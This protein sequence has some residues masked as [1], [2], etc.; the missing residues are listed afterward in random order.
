MPA[1]RR[2]RG[3]DPE[4]AQKAPAA[5]KSRVANGDVP[6]PAPRGRGRPR[7]A[8]DAARTSA[9]PPVLNTRPSQKL[10]IYVFGAGEFGELGLGSKKHEDKRPTNVKQP[11]LNHLLS[12][13]KVGVVQ[14]ACGGMHNIALTHDNRVLTWGVNDDKALGRETNWEGDDDDD[15]DDDAGLD[16][17]E[18]TPAE[19][20]F[21][22]LDKKPNF[23]Q[24]AATNSASFALTD[25]GY[26]YGWGTFRGSDGIF[27]FS[28][29]VEVQARPVKVAGLENITTLAAGSDHMLA[30]DRDGR[31]LTWGSGG[32]YQL[33]RK[34]VS[35]HGGPKATLQPMVCGRFT[36][37][38]HAVKI[39]AGA[40]TGFYIDNRSNVWSW[41]L[42]NYSQT[43]HSDQAGKS[44]AVVPAPTVVRAFQ[45]KGIIHIDGGAHHSLACSSEGELFTFGRVDGH[46]LGLREDA[47]NEENTIFDPE[48]RP[49]ILKIPTVVPDVKA[50]FV[51]SGSDTSI[52]I[53]PDGRGYSWGFSENYQTGQATR[54]D[55][56]VPTP[57]ESDDL[58]GKRLV[59]AGVGGQYGMVASEH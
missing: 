34:P 28:P 57:V 51:A 10:D 4:A 29:E 48:G 13:D 5:K 2:S 37:G 32:Q 54:K 15:D 38:R 36:K 30:L 19:V 7:R 18:S 21:G 46:Q 23:V 45:K 16:P 3:E 20:N 27:G 55:V 50:S 43:G 56:E 53:S 42:N 59:W 39:A 44:N 40:Y 12:A 35:R 58:A 26:V 17:Q 22:S 31:V 33:A 9:P 41:G 52:A 14:I 1:P 24:V 25:D 49:R 11:R 8:D 6:A 47:F